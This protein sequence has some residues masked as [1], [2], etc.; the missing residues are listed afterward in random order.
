MNKLRKN[1]SLAPFT[2]Y[3]IG[4]VADYFV[5][6]NSTVE[7]VESVKFAR[8]KYLPVFVL[9]C[10]ANVLI[11]DKGFRGMVILNRS[12]KISI[13]GNEVVTDSGV[14]ISDLINKTKVLG[15]SG[16]EH[17]AGIPSSVGGAIRQ[18]LHFLTPDRND[19]FYLSQILKEVTVLNKKN[20][21]VVLKNEDLKFGYDDSLLHKEELIVL[22][23][24]FELK[25]T[26]KDLV[27]VLIE[28]NLKWREEKHPDWKELPSCGSVFKKIDGVGAGR[29]I[30][31][32]GLKGEKLGK[33]QISPKH[34]NFLVNLGGATAVEVK[35]LIELIQREVKEKTGYVLEPEIGFVG[36]F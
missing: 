13:D 27:R 3:K 28:E 6:V 16:F 11:S 31:Q 25:P 15:L 4:G 19:T 30:E 23:A 18:N 34:A 8:E 17:F 36:E 12:G 33:V 14:N 1:I 35:R 5:E 32:A 21:V 20:E 24:T 2:T 9:G 7:L 26:N 22:D 10:G 29:L